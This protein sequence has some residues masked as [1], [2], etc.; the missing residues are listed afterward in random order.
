MRLRSGEIVGLNGQCADDSGQ[1]VSAARPMKFVGELD[2]GTQFSDC[3]SRDHH[4]VVAGYPTGRYYPT[5][6]H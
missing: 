2:A 3:D 4:V 1:E 5:G 6:R